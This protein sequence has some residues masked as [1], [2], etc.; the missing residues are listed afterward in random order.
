MK[1]EELYIDDVIERARKLQKDKKMKKKTVAQLIQSVLPT[2]GHLYLSGE[3]GTVIIF[4]DENKIYKEAVL[5]VRK[6]QPLPGNK[7]F[8]LANHKSNSP[9]E[10]AYYDA[11]G[12]WGYD[13]KDR[14]L[15]ATSLIL[16]LRKAQ[17]DYDGQV[18]E[19]SRT[20][21]DSHNRQILFKTYILDTGKIP[22][23]E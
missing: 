2:E 15:H 17:H 12:N 14:R 13:D 23:I 4:D 1:M 19:F 7:I 8:S 10:T 22:T 20:I 6:C 11:A 3:L 18:M 5:D 21:G 16:S 9:I